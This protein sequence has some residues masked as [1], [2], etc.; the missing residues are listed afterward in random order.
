MHFISSWVLLLLMVLNLSTGQNNKDWDIIFNPPEVTAV[1]GLCAFISCTF[2]YP[3]KTEHIQNTLW[4]SCNK[5]NICN[6]TI[7]NSS[8]S[9]RQGKSEKIQIDMLE[10]DP[11]KKNCSIILK[12]IKATDQKQYAFRVEW[13][14]TQEFTYPTRLKVVIQ[15]KPIIDIPP[16]REGEQANLTCS[17]PFP[18]PQTP[19]DITFWIETK[20]E[21]FK[22]LQDSITLTNNKSHYLST[23]TLTP[24]SKLHNAT[25]RC[26]VSY[27]PKNISTSRTLEVTNPTDESVI[28][29]TIR[30]T[31]LKLHS[32][33]SEHLTEKGQK[34]LTDTRGTTDGNTTS[35]VVQTFETFLKKLDLLTIFTFLTGMA[36]SAVI[37]SVTLCCWVSCRRVK[38]HKVLTA[39][40]D[41]GVNL[42][43]DAGT[44]DKAAP[45]GLAVEEEAAGAEV[46]EV[47][48][49]TIDYSLLE[50]KPAEEEERESTDTEYAEIKRDTQGKGKKYEDVQ[51]EMSNAETADQKQ[52]GEEEIYSN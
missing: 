14:N 34:M 42:E 1:P 24:T 10:M 36:C 33:V 49:A 19:P 45:T 40:P 43:L 29:W 11:N 47:T 27:G 15:E 3:D 30:P 25:V 48:Y 21:D 39:N 52:K 4:L 28:N 8:I 22:G 5:T 13:S 17:A 23:L 44:P 41:T 26:Q 32:T 6:N 50:K 9:G 7:F 18:C 51:N 20:S 35:V 38:K 2:T 16:L 31:D 37:I 12:N 46:G